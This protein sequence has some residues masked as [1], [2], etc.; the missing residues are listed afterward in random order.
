MK[1]KRLF[2]TF[3]TLILLMSF[4]KPQTVLA[5]G[6]N[7]SYSWTI[8]EGS[9][10]AEN[11]YVIKLY[12]HG[13][14]LQT[15]T[16]VTC[17]DAK[18]QSVPSDIQDNA[19]RNT[20]IKALN[21]ISNNYCSTGCT[22]QN[23]IAWHRIGSLSG[24]SGVL[25]RFDNNNFCI[26]PNA[27]FDDSHC[28]SYSNST[29]TGGNMTIAKILGA[30]NSGS[31]DDAH[32]AAAQIMLWEQLGTYVS[33]DVAGYWEARADLEARMNNSGVITS[34]KVSLNSHEATLKIGES[35]TSLDT[36]EH[37]STMTNKYA[38][39]NTEGLSVTRSGDT[40]TAIL[41]Q[42][43][44]KTKVVTISG[45]EDESTGSEVYNISSMVSP[46]SQNLITIGNYVNN[47]RINHYEGD[48]LTVNTSVGSLEIVKKDE[49]GQIATANN[50]FEIYL[51]DNN[52]LIGT[53]A[54]A[55]QGEHGKHLFIT[56]NGLSRFSTNQDGKIYLEN[57]LPDGDYILREVKTTNPYILNDEGM[58][59]TIVGG[60]QTQLTFVNNKRS[61]MYS[62]YKVDAEEEFRPLN[63]A[64]YSVYDVTNVYE[65]NDAQMVSKTLYIKNG[66]SINLR[67]CLVD[68]D[69]KL[70]SQIKNYPVIFKFN[71]DE[72]G[73]LDTDNVF[74]AKKEGVLKVK[75]VG[76]KY[77]NLYVK[78]PDGKDAYKDSVFNPY[79]L[80][81]FK[82]ENGEI[83]LDINEIHAT[84]TVDTTAIG[85]YSVI[86]EIYTKQGVKYLVERDVEVIADN[87]PFYDAESGKF[88]DP[89][90]NKEVEDPEVLNNKIIYEFFIANDTTLPNSY[91]DKVF[92][93]YNIVIVKDDNTLSNDDAFTYEGVLVFKGKTG[94]TYLRLID[95]ENHNFPLANHEVSLYRD[96]NLKHKLGDYVT[97]E[98]GMI[99]FG[100]DYKTDTPSKNVIIDGVS[101]LVLDYYKMYEFKLPIA[102]YS[103]EIASKLH[104]LDEFSYKTIMIGDDKEEAYSS[105]TLES[106]L[107]ESF[108]EEHSQDEEVVFE[109]YCF[110]EYNPEDYVENT[111]YYMLNDKL[112]ET[113]YIVNPKGLCQIPSLKHSRTYMVIETD[114]PE[115]YDYLDN[116]NPAYLY[117]TD[118][119]SGV[120][121]KTDTQ[122]NILRR[123]KV[124]LFKTNESK[125]LPLNGAIFDVYTS[126]EE[127]LDLNVIK[128]IKPATNYTNQNTEYELELVYEINELSQVSDYT[129]YLEND[130][131]V[132]VDDN[133]D[134]LGSY[135]YLL[136]HTVFDEEMKE[137]VLNI[138][139]NV[140]KVYV[141]DT[142]ERKYLG[143]YITGG[144]YLSYPE[145]LENATVSIFTDEEKTKLLQKVSLDSDN[146]AQVLGLSDGLYYYQLDRPVRDDFVYTEY[147]APSGY[148]I[149][150][151]PDSPTY[152][153][154]IS[155]EDE[156]IIKAAIIKTNIPGEDDLLPYEELPACY[157]ELSKQYVKSGHILLED[158]KYGEN[159]IFNELK[160]PSGYFIDAAQSDV[161]ALAPYGTN[162]V[163]TSKINKA[164]I[165]AKTGIRIKAYEN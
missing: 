109:I 77:D 68:N 38:I 157:K 79:R 126:K 107:S 73:S 3:L 46:T 125:T 15:K 5:N 23:N 121:E 63:D 19:Q 41:T 158:I 61:V 57:E 130:N 84:S 42:P 96:K 2:I 85:Q 11:T 60:K 156:S 150:N 58:P 132:V 45:V 50:V 9:G 114:L 146:T 8:T 92:K 65:E 117:E 139:G 16:F 90:T 115:G 56:E 154:A 104:E 113:Q 147:I 82:D 144:I 127:G 31:H 35:T 67:D 99:D 48:R 160:A 21:D 70:K 152:L 93:E 78:Y 12:Y 40:I 10:S 72:F 143:R 81:I 120:D 95:E 74:T 111:V 97:D 28:S 135:E 94:H 163:E 102:T 155:D 75:V 13:N 165:I 71:N 30:Y 43:Y 89:I 14:L 123:L 83:P 62:I 6:T 59:F 100:L 47:I 52:P 29:F 134:E 159:V 110:D 138:T 98:A 18:N 105:I 37:L 26:E 34:Y 91:V 118:Y 137:D 161:L 54:D 22:I 142:I 153:K 17:N 1:I 55:G 141:P 32:Y 33:T 27:L 162:L 149:D 86:Y 148:H 103:S 108:I 124:S 140:Y 25:G 145:A 49:F 119:E 36:E 136:S 4:G 112:Y 20:Y 39:S 128:S 88:I 101:R 80:E 129:I 69:A 106:L 122:R 151:N 116:Y 51:D 76:G 53:N 87:R 64:E 7:G 24:G 164:L 66:K 44:P 133:G 131:Y